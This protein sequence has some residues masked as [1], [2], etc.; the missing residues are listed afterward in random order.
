[1]TGWADWFVHVDVWFGSTNVPFT[2]DDV[3]IWFC[4][5]WAVISAAVAA[6]TAVFLTSSKDVDVL[7]TTSGDVIVTL[8]ALSID[9][10]TRV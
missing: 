7:L 5:V 10:S 4:R 3:L 9:C 8:N 1:M 6:A 2:E